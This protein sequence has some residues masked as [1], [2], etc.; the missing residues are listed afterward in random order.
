MNKVEKQFV[1]RAGVIFQPGGWFILSKANAIEF[2]EQCQKESIGILGFDG[3][4]LREKGAIQ[5]SMEH[6]RDYSYVKTEVYSTAIDFIKT[7][8]DEMYFEI[9]CS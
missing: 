9:V 3:F 4:F 6:S 1:D 5:P 8:G 2:I 7:C